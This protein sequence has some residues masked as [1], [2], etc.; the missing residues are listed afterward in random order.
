MN[1]GPV[2]EIRHALQAAGGV[3]WEREVN[4]RE[5]SL[6]PKRWPWQASMGITDFHVPSY[7]TFI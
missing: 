6:P 2:L 1:K 3:Y 4:T 7:K 5:R